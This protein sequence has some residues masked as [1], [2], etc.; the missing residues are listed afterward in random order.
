MQR[1]TRRAA[2]NAA[3]GRR[4]IN[5]DTW[6][7]LWVNGTATMVEI[8]SDLLPTTKILFNAIPPTEAE[9]P[10]KAWPEYRHYIMDVLK[11]ANFAAKFGVESHQYF[12]NYELDAYTVH[13]A[14]T[15]IPFI[16]NF[17]GEVDFVRSRG[18]MSDGSD[19]NGPGLYFW[20]DPVWNIMGTS[21]WALTFGLDVIDPNPQVWS[22]EEGQN[23]KNWTEAVWPAFEH[24]STYAGR[25]LAVSSP[26]AWVQLRDALDATDAERFPSKEFGDVSKCEKDP[27]KPKGGVAD[28]AQCAKRVNKIIAAHAKKGAIVSDMTAATGSVHDSRNRL[29]LNDIGLRIWPTNYGQY[30]TQVDPNGQSVGRWHVGTVDK[31]P[32]GNYARMTDGKAGKTNMTFVLDRG[33]FNT[34][35]AFANFN[36]TAVYLRV[37]FF[38]E[39][40]GSWELSVGYSKA[41]AAA[42]DIKFKT[43][44][45]VTKTNS[46]EWIEA[47]AT[48]DSSSAPSGFTLQDISHLRLGDS[49]SMNFGGSWSNNKK[50]TDDDTFGWL[51][52]S[53]IPFTY[54]FAAHVVDIGGGGLL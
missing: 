24:F 36:S 5:S 2:S 37:G 50:K 19:K 1:S 32:L 38:D 11:P 18:E 53:K 27:A 22:K 26:G 6:K 46:E 20:P 41:K 34:S 10:E 9:D 51:E 7:S 15:R 21:C 42:A 44:G 17:T 48:L 25:K 39:G 29:G 14:I 4:S 16:S 31:G 49:D 47:R 23:M 8:W 30:M 12:T 40:K 28:K 13:G 52:A 3:T 45:S 43:V 35:Q 54:D 33:V